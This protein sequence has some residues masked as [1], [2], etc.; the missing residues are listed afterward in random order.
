MKS[1]MSAAAGIAAVLLMAGGAIAAA[2]PQKDMVLTD[3]GRVAGV[4]THDGKAVGFKGIPFAAPPL[5]KLRW[6]PP[7]P[8]APWE[9]VRAADKFGASCIQREHGD[10]LPWTIEYLDK[11]ETSEDCLYLNVWTPKDEAT[12]SLPVVVFVHG[13]AFTEGSGAVPIYD[14]ENL[15]RQGLV[16]VTINYRLGVF[17]FFAYPELT[18]ISAHHS[19]GNYGLLDQLA[20]LKWV[21]ANIKQFG[22]DPE[23]VLVW[24]QSA[25]AMSVEALLASP[26]SVNLFHAAMADSG[27]G[28]VRGMAD[29]NTAEENGRKFADGL[30]ANDIN[31]LRALPADQLLKASL[32]PI[33]FGPIV[34]GWVLTAPPKDLNARGGDN[35]VP[36][37]TGYQAMDSAVFS[38]KPGSLDAWHAQNRQQFGNHAEEFE[39]LYPATTAEEA[40]AM[41]LQASQDRQRVGMWVWAAQRG[42]HHKS[43]VY[44]YYFDRAIPWP[45][46]PEFGAFHSGELPYFFLNQQVLDRPWE[47]ADRELAKTSAAYL[48]NFAADGDPNGKALPQWPATSADTPKVMELGERTGF[49]PLAEPAREAFWKAFLQSM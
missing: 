40:R 18:K 41:S 28:L 38:Q 49:M 39:K 44:T 34:D 15:A 20:A 4:R 10:S 21:R 2:G 8:V 26:L 7:E 13:G 48:K 31:A 45:Q 29:L 42:E 23:R 27:I 6:T 5:G 30:H 43:A 22:G 32:G 17:G 33:R 3:S 9:G 19:S 25:G 37:I 46:H 47:P 16:V 1:G 24:G 11:N 12:A 36:V 14:G 35:D